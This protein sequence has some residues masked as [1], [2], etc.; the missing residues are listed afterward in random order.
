MLGA[1]LGNRLGLQHSFARRFCFRQHIPHGL[2]AIGV[3][4]RLGRHFQDR[5][6]GM[7]WGRDQYGIDILQGKQF[8]NVL[9]S[10]RSPAV[11]PRI[12]GRGFLAID[13]PQIADRNHLH[14]VAVLQLGR[15]QVEIAA[16]TPDANVSEGNAVVRTNNIPV[17][18]CR[19]GQDDPPGNHGSRFTQKC[20]TINS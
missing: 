14:V 15:D 6:M 3:F 17:G 12:R 16:A 9:D 1:N 19:V 2:F 18:Q 20:S 7:F 10:P 11:I 4:S 13:R 5:R 8:F